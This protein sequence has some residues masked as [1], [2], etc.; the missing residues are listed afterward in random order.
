[1][2]EI[3]D[4]STVGDVF[5]EAAARYGDQPFL[6]FPANTARAYAPQGLEWTYAQAA[7]AVRHLMARYAGAG[8][9]V[10]HRIG[11]LLEN[12]LEHFLHKLAMNALGVCCVPLNPD[13][14]PQE[15]A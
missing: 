13:H 7:T 12:R 9:G 5:F 6:A 8:Y 15:M 14:R 3:S 10:G 11:L 1:M 4:T 2:I